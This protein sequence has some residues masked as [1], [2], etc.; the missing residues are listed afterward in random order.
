MQNRQIDRMV[1]ELVKKSIHSKDKARFI[2]HYDAYDIDASDVREIVEA[3][4]FRFFSHEYSLYDI[5]SAYDP[6]LDWTKELWLQSGEQSLLGF[7]KRCN[8]YPLHYGIFTSFFET[9]KCNRQEDILYHE[10]AYEQK[11]MMNDIINIFQ[12]ASGQKPIFLLLNR[13]HFAQSSSLAFLYNLISRLD[14]CG[15]YIFGAYNEEYKIRTYLTDDMKQLTDLLE[16]RQLAVSMVFEEHSQEYFDSDFVPENGKLA[17]YVL[18]I[19]NMI[20]TGAYRQANYYL[21]FG[22]QKYQMRRFRAD[23]AD[24]GAWLEL[25]MLYVRCCLYRN[26]TG[27]AIRVA[28][29]IRAE[30]AG[31]K[32]RQEMLFMLS[33]YIGMSHVY[34]N[35]N[36]LADQSAAECSAIL[37]SYDDERLAMRLLILKD[38]NLYQGFDANNLIIESVYADDR[39]IKLL[40][41]Y[42]FTNHLSYIYTNCMTNVISSV[43][44]ETPEDR[45]CYE[46]GLRLAR[47]NDNGNCIIVFYTN[48]VILASSSGRFDLPEEY[49]KQIIHLIEEEGDLRALCNNYNGMGYFTCVDGCYWK[50]NEYYTKALKLAYEIQDSQLVAETLYNKCITSFIAKDYR[51]AIRYIELAIDIVERMGYMRFIANWSKLYGL[52]AL[53]HYYDKNEYS[54]NFHFEK[55]RRFLSHVLD[56][57][58]ES[59][60][61]FWDDDLFIFYTVNGLLEKGSG[62]YEQALSEFEHSR[63]HLL[64]TPGF[65]FF[66]Y[67]I[68]AREMADCYE[69]LD[70]GQ[71][72]R[73]ILEEAVRELEKRNYYAEVPQLNALLNNE[74]Y[75]TGTFIFPL[76][77]E[78]LMEIRALYNEAAIKKS[79]KVFRNDLEY[80]AAWQG[81]LA[82]NK[83]LEEMCGNAVSVAMSHFQ[84]DNLYLFFRKDGCLKL[85]L[86]SDDRLFT[87]DELAVIERFAKAYPNGFVMSRFEK[88]FY[89]FEALMQLFGLNDIVSFMMAAYIRDGEVEGTAI[90]YIDMKDNLRMNNYMLGE[91]DLNIFK[92]TYRQLIDFVEKEQANRLVHDMNEKLRNANKKL[93]EIAIKDALTGI[94][95]RQGLAAAIE[96]FKENGTEECAVVYFDLDNFKYYNDTFGHDIGDLIL[97]Q[98]ARILRE[99]APEQGI[100]I[101]YGGDEFLLLLPGEGEEKGVE[102]ARRFYQI[103]A[104]DNYYVGKIEEKLGRSVTIPDEKL[105]SSS[106]GISASGRAAGCDI[107]GAIMHADEALYRIKKTTKKNYITWS[108]V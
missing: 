15:V 27:N 42:N 31:T 98:F 54:C 84:T 67:P 17:Y 58:D 35:N 37:D 61:S 16:R 97:V 32:D 59:K 96:E 14:K 5:Q 100:P 3:A 72:R 39:L 25:C 13:I 50:S 43:L 71:E 60:Y 21:T 1:G 94:Y 10:I 102:L 105:I 56:T 108:S 87:D 78:L 29:S 49:Y 65:F 48:R 52:A 34:N 64:R 19:N 101:R 88:D 53:A 11:R 46:E 2:R 93:E 103:L 57:D 38:I 76:D 90:A 81:V 80:L 62:H 79:N 107:N 45:E 24:Y 99:L 8:V 86:Q 82:E 6:F 77:K 22:M 30:L 89:L 23:D 7:L 51:N 85:F 44:K 73:E 41:K 92:V 75:Q 69:N 91:E 36:E 26:D 66:G 18:H 28:N 70:R 106:I 33:Y 55:M 47:Q 104:R 12:Y 4:G 9:G 74:D 20:E 40:K 83:P 95:N 63:K 68:L